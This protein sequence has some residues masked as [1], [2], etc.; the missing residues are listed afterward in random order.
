MLKLHN[1][2]THFSKNMK[3]VKI[4]KK[5][6]Q[7]GC[8][9]SLFLLLGCTHIPFMGKAPQ[10]DVN[11]GPILE[12]NKFVEQG[13]II[14]AQALKTGKNIAVVPFTASVGVEANEAL[15]KVAL[16]IVKGISDT[17]AD[18]QGQM[19][20]RFT[21]LTA[22]NLESA[23]FIVQGHISSVQSPSKVDRWVLLKGQKSLGADGKMINAKTGETVLIFADA[24]KTVTKAEDYN[25][26]GYRIG[27]N[28]GLFILSGDK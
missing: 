6:I 4:M 10:S 7:L 19:Q 21:V 26:L 20:D 12:S 5:T 24:Q 15:D 18:E 23:D 8:A 14:D 3:T 28:I 25:Q 1:Q 13:K 17:F 16:M 27:K 9:I 11:E 2:H 22:E